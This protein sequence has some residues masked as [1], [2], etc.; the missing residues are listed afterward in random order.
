M[1]FYPNTLPGLAS[2]P[3][4]IPYTLSHTLSHTHTHIFLTSRLLWKEQCKTKPPPN[5]PLQ[6]ACKPKRGGEGKRGVRRARR[7]SGG[8][9]RKGN[10]KRWLS[11]TI[12]SK[13]SVPASLESNRHT[14]QVL[15]CACLFNALY[16]EKKSFWTLCEHKSIPFRLQCPILM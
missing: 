7:R 4:I 14:T 6:V 2:L 3:Q 11:L 1:V 12:C 8:E 9:G 13:L 10:I 15:R 16:P 5:I